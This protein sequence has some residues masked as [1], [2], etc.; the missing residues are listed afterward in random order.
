[1][2]AIVFVLL[3]FLTFSF[4]VETY[5]PHVQDPILENWRWRHFSEL[6]GK[7]V[8]C[9]MEDKKHNMWFGTDKG[10]I[11]Y[12][13][14]RWEAID[15]SLG[16]IGSPVYSLLLKSDGKLVAGSQGGI[17]IYENEKWHPLFPSSAASSLIIFHIIELSNR[18]LLCA[19]NF[20]LIHISDSNTVVYTNEKGKKFFKPFLPA[21]KIVIL[22]KNLM[23]DSSV[24]VSSVLQDKNNRIWIAVGYENGQSGR[25]LN[26][27]LGTNGVLKN[28]TIRYLENK[29]K[30]FVNGVHLFQSKNGTIWVITEQFDRGVT[31]FR[32]G[33]NVQLKL[34]GSFG[35][36]DIYSSIIQTTDNTIFIGALG[37]FYTFK[38]GIWKEYKAPIAPVPSSN[39]IL[40][41]NDSKGN[42]WMAGK[43]NEVFLL[44][45]TL[46]NWATYLDLNFQAEE[47]NGTRWFIDIKG[48]VIKKI[49]NKWLAYT[50]DDGMMSHPVRVYIM[51]TG[52]ILA[53]GSHHGI[54]C[55]A[56]YEKGHWEKKLYPELSWGIDVR[57]VYED[58]S[59]SLWLGC[60]ID[61]QYEKGQKGGILKYPDALNKND[62]FIHYNLP[63]KEIGVYGIGESKDGRFWVAGISVCYFDGKEW[64]PALQP[65]ELQYHSDCMFTS[66]DTILWIGSRNYGLFRFDGGQ[67][68]NYT[69][70]DGLIS[71]SITNI[72]VQS[73]S[74][75]WVATA[76]DISRFDGISWANKIFP[77]ELNILKEGGEIRMD[78][79]GNLWIN[80]S[81]RLWYRRILKSVSI[82]KLREEGF[83]TVFYNPDNF[84]P[85]TH[86]VHY[87]KEV[88]PI[89]NTTI[90]WS[91]ND[92]FDKTPVKNLQYSFRMDGGEWSPFSLKTSHFF[93]QLPSG[94]HTFEIRSRD[95]DFNVD[96]TP[97]KIKFYVL[98]PFY[99]R[100]AFFVPLII[101]LIIIVFLLMRVIKKSRELRQAKKE[102]DE[103]LR[104]IKQGLFLLDKDLNLGSQYSTFLKNIFKEDDLTNRNFIDLIRGKVLEE[105]IEEIRSYL[106]LMFKPDIDEISLEDL[107]PFN[108]IKFDYPNGES[109]TK[110]YSFRFRKI[111]G[112]NEEYDFGYHNLIVVVQDITE[113]IILGQELEETK[114]NTARKMNW[115]LDI[116]HVEPTLLQ[117]FLNSAESEIIKI[118]DLLDK[119]DFASN[120][121]KYLESI[122]RSM[123]LLKGNAGLLALNSFAEEA[124]HVEDIIA[125]LQQQDTITANDILLLR[126]EIDKISNSIHDV[127][128]LLDKL[129]AI[130]K[131]MRTKREFEDGQLKTSLKNLVE[132]I[133]RDQNKHVRLVCNKFKLHTFPYKN[134]FN[135]RNVLIQ[136]IKN[137]VVHGIENEEERLKHKKEKIGTI[138]ISSYKNDKEYG[139]KVRDDGRGIQI[140]KLISKLKESGKYSVNE[141]EKLTDKEIA[142]TIFFSGLSTTEEVDINAGR[143]VGLDAVKEKISADGGT[144][145]VHFK[146]NVF[147]EFIVRFPTKK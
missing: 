24:N 116:L 57:G 137:A 88:S 89:G 115:L 131:Q 145:E 13:G 69:I 44:D 144:I 14:L 97:A 135:V 81:S 6:D 136:L 114:E 142:E 59:G 76:K 39:R 4:A 110:Y 38:D 124:H 86:I 63:Q 80:K 31:L 93:A 118:I 96:P 29:H 17:S 147:C 37:R 22:N 78:R 47:E 119:Q 130:H 50:E 111:H 73:D 74:S 28:F 52:Q 120:H 138:E 25:I 104:N 71:N 112:A 140:D 60:N 117:E 7:G 127:T 58:F 12:D 48:R 20:G 123:H 91:G 19:S 27:R 62:Y 67:W 9:M 49:K 133:S 64:K 108:E 21:D 87:E 129:S 99:L 82:Q 3:L 109:P 83:R 75:V 18:S 54:A 34:S 100:P 2:K 30:K 61:I 41:F 113:Q 11:K 5:K 33:K 65:K 23:Q 16:L 141:I 53:A 122:Y 36:D 43:Q 1:M 77:Q 121:K 90:S 15:T 66:S 42:I 46:K 32:Q 134:H 40:F 26:A 55:T 132:Q 84:A 143:G 10:L 103:I 107:N 125:G 95:L 126:N 56:F 128:S 35:G 101:L 51:R 85:E 98:Y 79:G 94:M 139:F 102:T 106:E 8:R 72:F 68:K 70:N 45:Y 92:F 146:K 105:K